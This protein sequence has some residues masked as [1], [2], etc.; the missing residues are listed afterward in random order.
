MAALRALLD[1]G[2]G[3]AIVSGEAGIGK[4]RLVR[5]FAAEAAERGRVVLWGRPEEVAQ[6][7]P[8]AL[9]VDLL[10]SIAERGKGELKNE[11]RALE[12]EMIRREADDQQRPAPNP[13]AVAAE[14]RGIVARLNAPP[15]IVLEDLHWADEASH[16]VALH[17]ARAARD[18]GHIIVA[19]TRTE[20][21]SNEAPLQRLVDSLIRDRI[22]TVVQL[23]PFTSQETAVMLEQ[24]WGRP[25]RDGELHRL[26]QVGEG[27]PFFIEEL[28]AA[29]SLGSAIPQ[30]VEQS[31][32]TR[33]RKLGPDTERVLRT[34]SLL[35]GTLDTEVLAVAC[36]MAEDAVAQ[37]LIHATHASILIDLDGR[38]LF[39]HGLV[40]D[41]VAAG[42]VSIEAA[43]IHA[44]IAKAIL[45]VHDGGLAPFSEALALHYEAAGDKEEASR[46]AVIAGERALSLG[47]IEEAR[48]HFGKAL[49]SSP[50]APIEA[51]RGLAEVE[52]R[53]ANEREAA[54]LYRVVVDK[55][56][57][58]GD[59]RSA[60]LTLGRLAWVLQGYTSVEAAL[61]AINEGLELLDA[62]D[63]VEFARLKV[64]M[65]SLLCFQQRQAAAA[66]PILEE[67]FIA[68]TAADDFSLVAEALDALAQASD[69]EGELDEA[70]GLGAQAIDSALKSG[71][72]E[73][74]GRAHHNHAVKLASS[75]RSIEALEVLAHGREFLRSVYGR[76]AIGALDVGEAWVSW[77]L[78]RP[79]SV[80][81]LT[82][83]GRHAWQRWRGYRWL[84]ET[85]ASIELGDR[86]AARA[87]IMQAW[88]ELGGSTVHDKAISGEF[89]DPDSGHALH[90][91]ALLE[92]ANARGNVGPITAAVVS[93]Y[94]RDSEPFDRGQAL[95]L[96][97]R[98][99]AASGDNGSA[100]KV[101]DEV[102]DL[103]KTY[104]YPYLTAVL[105]ELQSTVAAARGDEGVA[106]KHLSDAVRVFESC[107]NASDRARCIRLLAETSVR[108]AKLAESQTIAL[109]KEARDLALGSGSAVELN[110]IE[111]SLRSLGV[112]PRAGRPR[113]A[114]GTKI[115]GLSAREAEVAALV[116]G[117]ETNS[118]IAAKLFLSERTVQDHITHALRKLSLPTRA[119]LASWAV[120]QGII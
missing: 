86:N 33:V 29:E 21:S 65:G 90:A 114:V 116:A 52:F 35:A 9:I 113:G 25:P 23:R 120:K 30:N 69:Q 96:H 91:E 22:A 82:A 17:L 13:R 43:Q 26:S 12:T 15:M 84:L 40:R 14:I 59:L 62:A 36:D 102:A 49:E 51:L 6:P 46:Y 32:R 34:A 19:S 77:L 75:G 72:A 100:Q 74:S 73:V 66:R 5:E 60:A 104:P 117:G 119:G 2:G 48:G 42:M 54:R 57:E 111:A 76:A 58:E 64:Q 63:T 20:G 50:D 55:F 89:S 88:T 67:G 27:V 56:K 45:Q 95:L 83:R 68:A 28:A 47:A 53:D 3:V 103:L 80:E 97:G 118:A 87:T 24:L 94:E 4:S 71:D 107:A 38:L 112:R 31:V 110:H 85:W 44:R 92:L 115:G 106:R 39:R 79:R 93:F 108:G 70:L 11:A 99:L 78:G 16:S 101:V 18:D 61:E 81:Q 109:L 8:F 7:G 37:V 105:A 98:A 10:E 1:A 41:A